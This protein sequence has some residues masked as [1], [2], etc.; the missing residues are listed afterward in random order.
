MELDLE[1]E[2]LV[3]ILRLDF[4]FSPEQDDVIDLDLLLAVPNQEGLALEGVGFIVNLGADQIV[5]IVLWLLSRRLPKHLGVL[6]HLDLANERA[7]RFGVGLDPRLTSDSLSLAV[8]R[9]LQ[10]VE[11][12]VEEFDVAERL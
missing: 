11:P 2:V 1:E 8:D 10:V 9:A 3:E 6:L 7:V 5:V 12:L 4:D